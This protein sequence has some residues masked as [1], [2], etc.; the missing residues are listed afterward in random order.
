MTQYWANKITILDKYDTILDNKITILDKY[1][2]IL[3]K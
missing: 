2:T 3:G 1:Y